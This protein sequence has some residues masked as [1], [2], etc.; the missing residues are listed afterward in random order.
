[1]RRFCHSLLLGSWVSLLAVGCPGSGGAIEPIAVTPRAHDGDATFDDL[2]A[3]LSAAVT[4][5]GEVDATALAVHLPRLDR[6]LSLLAGPWPTDSASALSDRRLAWLYNARM[7]WSLRIVARELHPLA[8][9]GD[10]FALPETIARRRLLGTPF[11]LNGRQTTLDEIDRRLAEADDFRLAVSAPGASDLVGRLATEPFSADSV[12]RLLARRFCDTVG[13]DRRVRVDHDSR[14][15]CVPP[16]LWR[17]ASQLRGQYNRRFR[18]RD[19]S[20]A[21]A[22]RP[23]LDATGRRRTADAMGYPARPR[24]GP[25]G[26]VARRLTEAQ[27]NRAFGVWGPK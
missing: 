11:P 1:M 15:L 27:R 7:A 9:R 24:T 13:D 17:F 18:T 25:P 16:A 22:L 19:A 6:Q 12:R 21:T 4:A 2:A 20:L 5:E 10:C 23:Y 14:S 3:V 8:R 26:I